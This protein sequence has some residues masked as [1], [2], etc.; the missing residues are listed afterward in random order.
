MI[1]VVDSIHCC[2]K[3]VVFIL[4][5]LTNSME[6]LQLDEKLAALWNWKVH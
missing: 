1:T 5:Y 4:I 3:Y 6:H 2:I